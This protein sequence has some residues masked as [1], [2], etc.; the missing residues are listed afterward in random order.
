MD[1]V[2]AEERERKGRI[3]EAQREKRASSLFRM[4]VGEGTCRTPRPTARKTETVVTARKW[5]CL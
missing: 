2:S 1:R 5:V 3:K 4:K